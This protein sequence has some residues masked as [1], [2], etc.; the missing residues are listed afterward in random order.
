MILPP[1]DTDISKG[2][3]ILRSKPSIPPPHGCDHSPKPQRRGVSFGERA[4]LKPPAQFMEALRAD[5]LSPAGASTPPC[6][7]N[8]SPKSP[9]RDAHPKGTRSHLLQRDNVNRQAFCP[10][11]GQCSSF[12]CDASPVKKQKPPKTR[13]SRKAYQ[14]CVQSRPPLPP[15]E[16]KSSNQL[17]Q[18]WY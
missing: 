3:L 18:F 11:K 10:S 9:H 15:R 16:R 8:H 5:D 12:W 13:T 17:F 6:G 1:Q 7:C 2:S 4:G 14:F